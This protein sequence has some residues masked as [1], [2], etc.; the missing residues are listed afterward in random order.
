M[1][2]HAIL[3]LLAAM[4]PAAIAA[5]ANV[6]VVAASADTTLYEDAAGAFANGAGESLFVGRI[7]LGPVRRG[8]IAFDVAAALPPGARVVAVD[9]VLQVARSQVATPVPMTLHRAT[10]S[11][12]EGT[13]NAT[14]GREGQGVLAGPGDSTWLHRDRP[15]S[16]WAAPGGDY[17]P[18]PHAVAATPQFG[19][20]TWAATNAMVADVQQ[21]LDAPATNFGWL[22]RTDELVPQEARRF[23]SRTASAPGVPP[24]LVVTWLMPGSWASIGLGC[25]SPAPSLAVTGA[26]QVGGAFALELHG[27]PGV[28]GANLVAPLL[29]LPPREIAPSCAF[30]LPLGAVTPGLWLLDANGI[31]RDNFVVP[32]FAAFAGVPLA[33]QGAVLDPGQPL[34]FALANAVQLFVQ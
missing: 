6:T 7:A 29:D 25:G 10:A 34:G 4:L 15:A 19:R 20:A 28:L 1:R 22:L 11:W 12:N 18:L 31:A 23:D 2:I 27:A 33:A 13:A 5:Q 3:L 21:W 17:D 32:P 16:L 30:W 24:Q 9:L 26:L 8:L 14:F